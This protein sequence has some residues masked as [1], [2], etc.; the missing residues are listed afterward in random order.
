[1]RHP[2]QVLTR[3]QIL[4]HT[5]DSDFYGDSNVVDVYIG[6]LRR[7]ID[8]GFELPLLQTVRGVGYRLSADHG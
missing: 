3:N 2:R 4:E 1:M 5:W 6:Y 7:K 8:Q